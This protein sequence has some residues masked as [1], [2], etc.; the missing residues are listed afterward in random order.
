MKPRRKRE[1]AIVFSQLI[2]DT[3]YSRRNRAGIALPQPIGYRVLIQFPGEVRKWEYIRI[4]FH[5][6]LNCRDAIRCMN[7]AARHAMTWQKSSGRKVIQ[8]QLPAILF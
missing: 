7:Q 3:N 4:L 8:S 1:E 2:C 5:C 6:P